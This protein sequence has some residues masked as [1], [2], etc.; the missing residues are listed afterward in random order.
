MLFFSGTEILCGYVNDTVCID[1]ESN[2]DLRHTSS[3]RRDT[4]ETELAESLVVAGK[5]SLTLGYVDIYCSLV[6]LCGGEY[7]ALLYGD[8]GVSL[9]QLGCNTAHGLDCK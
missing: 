7:L 4:V 6:I 5:L 8:G 3:C 2:F 9:N 1:I